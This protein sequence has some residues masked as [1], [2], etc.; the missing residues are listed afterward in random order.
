MPELSKVSFNAPTKNVDGSAVVAGEITS[1]V[2]FI[3]TVNPPLKSYTVPAAEAA[4]VSG[5]VTA[6]FA[7]L[8][9]TPVVGTQYYAG[10]EAVAGGGPSSIS[11]IVSFLYTSA[12]DAPTG[13]TIS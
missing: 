8:G 12:P 10:A 4:P 6:T 9:F 3:D 13:F 1:Y 11:N 5:V 2:V 7:Q